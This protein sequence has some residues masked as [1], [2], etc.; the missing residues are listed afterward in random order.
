MEF[1]T[2]NDMIY[3]LNN[4]FLSYLHASYQSLKNKRCEILN[5]K[6]ENFEEKF[7]L[8]IKTKGKTSFNQKIW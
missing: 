1:Q 5:N 3:E 7:L 2:E 8:E 6:L 4:L